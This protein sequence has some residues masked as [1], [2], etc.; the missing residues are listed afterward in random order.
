MPMLRSASFVV[1]LALSCAGMAEAQS[2]E[3]ARNAYAEG[4]FIEAGHLA[5]QVGTSQ[6]YALASKS[7]SIHVHYIEKDSNQGKAI[8]SHAIELAQAAVDADP[9]SADAYLQLAYAYGRHA[10]L[11]SKLEAGKLDYGNK[12]FEAI[13]TAVELAPDYSLAQL[14]LGRWHAGIIGEVGGLM[15]RTMFKARRKDAITAFE[16]A[17][18]LGPVSKYMHY[19]IALGLADLNRRKDRDTA[20]ERFLQSWEIPPQDAYE[21]IWHD[22]AQKH[23]K[24]LNALSN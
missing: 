24:R 19:S 8:I 5:E 12:T 1:A 6:G 3:A 2:I 10:H 15:A 20:R 17:E 16:Q 11:I 9:N 7:L 22:E 21:Q 13:D 23:L 18:R 4:R 14:N